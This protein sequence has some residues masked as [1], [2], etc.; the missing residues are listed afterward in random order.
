MQT[1]RHS[2]QLSG[3][4]AGHRGLPG[5]EEGLQI[6]SLLP[7]PPQ[8]LLLC[9]PPQ[10]EAQAP[11]VHSSF[12][13]THRLFCSLWANSMPGIS[14]LAD[15]AWKQTSQGQDSG[16]VKGSGGGRP[17][18]TPTPGFPEWYPA[19]GPWKLACIGEGGSS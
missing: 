14:L 1:H 7:G 17:K 10:T 2:P 8:R 12:I 6:Q 18:E 19:P 13:A 5:T 3:A 9:P 4:P 16:G 11:M 15:L